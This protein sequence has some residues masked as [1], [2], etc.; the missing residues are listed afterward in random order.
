MNER[1]GGNKELMRM[2]INVNIHPVRL[3]IVSR[4]LLERL[5]KLNICFLCAMHS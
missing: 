5:K 2:G 1:K 4:L 3:H